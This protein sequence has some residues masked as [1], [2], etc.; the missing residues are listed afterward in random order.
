MQCCLWYGSLQLIK[1]VDIHK[2]LN[3]NVAIYGSPAMHIYHGTY[4]V[5]IPT[6]DRNGLS[7][8][9]QLLGL[10]AGKLLSVLQRTG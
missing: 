8:K 10:L 7:A 6:H 4:V 2:E 3:I 5:A 9:M 1:C